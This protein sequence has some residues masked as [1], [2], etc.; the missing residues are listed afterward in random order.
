[1]LSVLCIVSAGSVDEASALQQDHTEVSG[2]TVFNG[3]SI[4][5]KEF[6]DERSK[7]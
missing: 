7:V 2:Y 3:Y 6:V 5:L 1:M 4:V